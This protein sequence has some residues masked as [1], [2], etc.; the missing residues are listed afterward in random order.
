MLAT[1]TSNAF[2]NWLDRIVI[3]TFISEQICPRCGR[4]DDHIDKAHEICPQC[5]IEV[6]EEEYD[7]D[8]I[9]DY[10]GEIPHQH[11]PMMYR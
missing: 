7:E 10:S 11:G 3:N 4:K 8:D 2:I 1:I 6:S 9:E 5:H